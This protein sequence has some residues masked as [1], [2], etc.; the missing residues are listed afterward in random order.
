MRRAL[1][2]L[3]GRLDG[4]EVAP[5]QSGLRLFDASSTALT[6]DSDKLLAVLPQELLDLVDA[7]IERVARFDFRELPAILLGVRFGVLT[8]LLRL[9]LR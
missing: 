9:V 5:S 7:V 8:H 4:F 3:R 2:F 1:Q 6:S